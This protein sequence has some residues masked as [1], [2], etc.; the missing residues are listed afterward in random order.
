MDVVGLE[1]PKLAEVKG[2][3]RDDVSRQLLNRKITPSGV[4]SENIKKLSQEFQN[5]YD[6]ALEEYHARR[7]SA[8][9]A[10]LREEQDIREAMLYTRYK[11]EEEQ[12]LKENSRLRTFVGLAKQ[13]QTDPTFAIQATPTVARMLYR[14][15]LSCD[16]IVSLDLSNG[17]IND[18]VGRKLVQLLS[19]EN[20]APNLR[21]LCLDSNNIGVSTVKA[22]AQKLGSNSKLEYLSL[23]NNDLTSGHQDDSGIRD[24]CCA[25]RQNDSLLGLNLSCT[26]LTSQGARELATMMLANQTIVFLDTSRNEAVE[27]SSCQEIARSIDRNVKE[28]EKL[29]LVEKEKAVTQYK[30]ALKHKELEEEKRRE[31]ATQIDIENRSRERQ[32]NRIQQDKEARERRQIELDSARQLAYE[33]QELFEQSSAK[34]KKGNKSK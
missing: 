12:A 30:Q 11:T 21:R 9:V 4:L 6:K 18:D 25:L 23:E 20:G 8:K 14:C 28:R 15:L 3:T 27:F 24:L 29:L 19:K 1:P 34:G 16:S 26:C 33:R 32:A 5:E 22:L 7:K 13:N 31:E 17:T 2:L 10:L